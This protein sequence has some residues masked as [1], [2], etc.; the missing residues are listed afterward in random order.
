MTGLMVDR[1]N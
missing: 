1:D